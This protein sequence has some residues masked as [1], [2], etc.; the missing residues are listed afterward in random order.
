MDFKDLNS[1]LLGVISALGGLGLVRL[2]V[3]G[4]AER[5]KLDTDNDGVRDEN[6]RRQIDWLE[7][8]VAERDKRIDKIFSELRNE[9]RETIGLMKKLHQL[10]SNLRFA[11][12]MKCDVV[13]CKDRK[14]SGN[15]DE[16]GTL[17]IGWDGAGCQKGNNSN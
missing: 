9:Q 1:A 15:D 11:Y 13:N 14:K 7:K 12:L 2:F 5:R 10:D 17:A 3:F 6:S 4:K 16:N 8:R